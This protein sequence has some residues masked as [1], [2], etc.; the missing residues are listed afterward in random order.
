MLGTIASFDNFIPHIRHIGRG[1]DETPVQMKPYDRYLSSYCLFLV[2]VLDST[3]LSAEVLVDD[4][5][6]GSE[7]ELGTGAFLCKKRSMLDLS[8]GCSR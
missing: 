5:V 3:T 4:E 2:L 6:D 8:V 1:H 7:S